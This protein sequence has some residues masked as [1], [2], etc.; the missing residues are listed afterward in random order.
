MS[1]GGGYDSGCWGDH[2][3]EPESG[4]VLNCSVHS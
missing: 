3:L 1:S 4:R 2:F